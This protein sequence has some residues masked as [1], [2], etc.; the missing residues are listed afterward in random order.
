MSAFDDY[1][2]SERARMASQSN[3]LS[4]QGAG[5]NGAQA[6]AAPSAP[7]APAYQ[8]RDD[9]NADLNRQAGVQAAA[10][11]ANPFGSQSATGGAQS[12]FTPSAPTS[13]AAGFQGFQSDL[14]AGAPTPARPSGNNPFAPAPQA[15]VSSAI[16]RLLSNP[17]GSFDQTNAIARQNAVKSNQQANED[18]RSQ[19]ALQFLPGS[20]QAFAP[21]QQQTDQQLLAM[22]D[23]DATAAANR[24]AAEQQG[25]QTGA[26]LGLQDQGQKLNA[27][28]AAAQ[29]AETQRQFNQ[30]FPLQ[31]AQAAS[32]ASVAQGN[33]GVSQGQLALNQQL[34]TGNLALN[35]Q[36]LDLQKQLGLGNLSLEQQKVAN[37]ASQFTS[38]L[39]YQKYALQKGMDQH[40]ADLAWQANQQAIQQKWQTGERLSSEEFTTLINTN[41]Q[42][43]DAAQNSLNRTLQLNMQSNAQGFQAA[44]TAA[45]QAF[46]KA[47]QESGFDQQRALQASQQVFQQE[48][49]KAGFTQE[50]T[51]QAAQLTQ[52][53]NLAKQQMDLQETMH[54]A[55]LAQSDKQFGQKLGLDYAQLTDQK[56][57]FMMNLQEQKTEFGKQFGMAMDELGLKKEQVNQALGDDQFQQQLEKAQIGMQLAKDNPDA[58]APFAKSLAETMGK[59]L[60]MTDD[61]IHQGVLVGDA[62]TLIQNQGS[63]A[64]PEAFAA[65]AKSQGY[66][67]AEIKTVTD[68]WPSLAGSGTSN[69]QTVAD[70]G[71]FVDKTGAFP[72]QD[73]ADKFKTDVADFNN[74]SSSLQ[75]DKLGG[76]PDE[77]NYRDL[78][79]QGRA[80][81]ARKNPSADM[82]TAFG[83]P[84]KVGDINTHTAIDASQRGM[85]YSIYARMQ[86]S[87][88][89]EKDAQQALI[90][91]VGNNR[92]ASALALE[93]TILP[94]T[95]VGSNA[96]GLVMGT[97]FSN[98]QGIKVG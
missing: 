18:L 59:A 21:A 82:S 24:T 17:T 92:A 57:Q 61:Q 1:L 34:G 54:M 47:M 90:K 16:S 4:P 60:G 12:P 41:Q 7:Q 62:K 9:R 73:A 6:T 39:D 11:K 37:Q 74:L 58:M 55:D 35:Q 87:G 29:L 26:S 2:A 85:D 36:Q 52:Q 70:F 88:L 98:L 78:L 44:Q 22:R 93:G 45:A 84:H 81:L 63:A 30:E 23:F 79:T 86:Q 80:A 72:T 71:N 89:S 46:D 77:Q 69:K 96:S 66:T 95:I 19:A 76:V 65:Q 56:Q 3:P 25:L 42:T 64:T 50:Q 20:G 94:Q 97:D 13:S 49:Q 31:A 5:M 43:F 33:L 8:F 53:A 10:I 48:M 14:E 38:Q 83:E 67:D 91:L 68:Q 75:P 51:M 15:S 27:Q 28:Q 32:Q 40:T